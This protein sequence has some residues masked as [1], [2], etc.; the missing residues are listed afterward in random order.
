MRFR[1]G[2]PAARPGLAY[3]LVAGH[4]TIF[5]WLSARW[6]VSAPSRSPPR[7]TL[8]IG[9]AARRPCLPSFRRAASPGSRRTRATSELVAD[10]THSAARQISTIS[11]HGWG[12]VPP[13]SS[14][15]W[16]IAFAASLLT[17]TI[18]G[19]I[20]AI[21]RTRADLVALLRVALL[22]DDAGRDPLPAS[23]NSCNRCWW[24]SRQSTHGPSAQLRLCCRSS[25][26][27]AAFFVPSRA[28]SLSP[29]PCSPS[30]T[31]AR[32]ARVRG[33]RH[34]AFRMMAPLLASQSL[35]SALP[36]DGE[37]EAL[38]AVKVTDTRL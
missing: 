29:R 30:R 3:V 17:A 20:P 6:R 14:S 8:A 7:A 13:H 33:S 26:L 35:S 22:R 10:D 23:R 19:L 16:V 21:R 27:S 34:G 11:I 15:S 5:A 9:T 2:R 28:A 37:N 12:G 32:C 4:C 36:V 25:R 31:A 1:P 24:R 38:A 18:A